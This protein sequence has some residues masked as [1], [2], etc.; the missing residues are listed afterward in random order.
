MYHIR[1][2]IF[3]VAFTTLLLE[4]T[5][6]R[7]FD[8]LWFTNMAYMII[9]LAM[10]SIGV[11]GVFISL[12]PAVFDRNFS[13][14]MPF[15]AVTMAVATYLILPALNEFQFNYK[16]INE[17]PAH[18]IAIFLVILAIISTPFLIAGLIIA[19]LF[20]RFADKIQS[21]YFWDLVG[22][23]AGCV[24]ILFTVED[25]GA[26]GLLILCTATA[27]ISA[28]FF[29]QIRVL[30]VILIVLAVAI[31]VKP[32][33]RETPYNI[34]PHMDKR[35]FAHYFH[36]DKIEHSVWDPVSSID[37]V[38]FREGI[39]WVAYDGGTQ[40]SYYYKFDGDFKALLSNLDELKTAQ[41]WGPYV[42]ASHYLKRQT[43][44][45]VLI[46]GAAV[47]AEVAGWAEALLDSVRRV[48]RKPRRHFCLVHR[49]WML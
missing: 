45:K 2:G 44:Q 39:K 36:N 15:L 11:S 18:A 13:R 9:T 16:A 26:P 23:A 38:D 14:L 28:A 47:D 43:K 37:I 33:I 25:Y 21:L 17:N 6:I 8:H 40:T 3:F 12:G 20:S 35:G 7:I 42:L 29:V 30:S 34:D 22:A 49:M 32:L 5:L 48:G 27:L 1:L 4:L 24:M 31:G 46:I 10:F 19:S 41:F